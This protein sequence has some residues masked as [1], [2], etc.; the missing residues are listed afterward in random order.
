[1]S[2]PDPNSMESTT[3]RKGLQ[4]VFALFLSFVFFVGGFVIHQHLKWM[5]EHYDWTWIIVYMVYGVPLWC[6]L[7]L[8]WSGLIFGLFKWRKWSRFRSAWIV[9]PSLLFFVHFVGFRDT[10]P[11]D[12]KERFKRLAKAELPAD[13]T[14]LRSHFTGY[15]LLS[16]TSDTYYF[17]CTPAQVDR[18]IAEMRLGPPRAYKSIA[19]YPW[20]K[21]PARWPDLKDWE[22]ASYY[23]RDGEGDHM[24]WSY[25]LVM[26]QARTEVYIFIGHI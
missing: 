12:P 13:I 10:A 7:M 1:M 11:P 6:I 9:G 5:P 19:D 17:R 18:L 24:G 21:S 25:E 16:D 8:P 23:R 26:N 15:G 4:F 20:I 14:D 2:L 22:G 3:R